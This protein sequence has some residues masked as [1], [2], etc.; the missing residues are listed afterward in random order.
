MSVVAGLALAAN[1]PDLLEVDMRAVYIDQYKL[2]P[3]MVPDIYGIQSSNKG[4]ERSTQVGAVPDHTEFMGKIDVIERTPGY[5]KTVTFTEFAAQI[6]IQRKL[7]ADDQHRVVNRFGKG[8]ATSANRSREKLGANTFI[9][10]F[11]YEPTDGDGTE[12]CASDHPSR[13]DG[14]ATQSN[15]GTL[16]FSAANI[17][18]TRLAMYEFKN[19]I[20]EIITCNPNTLTIPRDLEQTGWEIINSKGKVD[21]ADNNQNFLSGKYNLMIWDRLTDANNWWMSD[22]SM[23]KDYLYWWNREPIQFFQDKDSDTLVAKYLSYYRCGISWE[24]WRFIYGNLVS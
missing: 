14:V 22:L 18:T 3:A 13:V 6:Q 12:L 5:D 2:L 4:Y 7:A 8:L 11:T 23:Q 20:G 21:T 1:W 24:D 17:E 16:Q 9:L 10:A 19:D 15:E